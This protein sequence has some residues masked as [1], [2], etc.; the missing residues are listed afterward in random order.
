[1]LLS[2]L[3]KTVSLLLCCITIVTLIAIQG[4]IQ[5]YKNKLINI[6]ESLLLYNFAIMC[7]LLT[8]NGN[9]TMNIITINVMVGL[10]FLHF[11]IILLYHVFAFMIAIHC[12]KLTEIIRKVW[13]CIVEKC[14]RRGQ[15]DIQHE[16]FRMEIPEVQYNFANFRE[17]LIGED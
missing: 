12:T 3:G 1:M 4:H 11:L 10:S 2:V 16:R 14:Y 9:E 5:P 7:I 8:F 13:I 17:P 15:R 6:Q